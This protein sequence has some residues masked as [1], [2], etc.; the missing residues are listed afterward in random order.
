MVPTHSKLYSLAVSGLLLEDLNNM[1]I[2]RTK[3]GL[4]RDYCDCD[5]LTLL[6]AQRQVMIV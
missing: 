1:V 3:L 6:A 5:P 4:Y 2:A